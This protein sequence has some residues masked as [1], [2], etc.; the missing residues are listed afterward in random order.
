M[1]TI[2][3]DWS[4]LSAT[5]ARPRWIHTRGF[6]SEASVSAKDVIEEKRGHKQHVG[7]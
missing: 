4:C 3:P 1:P 6:L 5:G 2:P 7:D